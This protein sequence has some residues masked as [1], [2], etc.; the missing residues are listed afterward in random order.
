MLDVPTAVQAVTASASLRRKRPPGAR[1]R[2]PDP[3]LQHEVLSL[4]QEDAPGPEGQGNPVRTMEGAAPRFGHEPAAEEGQ[5]FALWQ[6]PESCY[7][8]LYPSPESRP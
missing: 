1:P 5:L 3:C 4:R 6:I 7:I 2:G 8:A